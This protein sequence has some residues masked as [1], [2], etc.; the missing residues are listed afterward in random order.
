MLFRYGQQS[1]KRD[2][3]VPPSRAAERLLSAG[4]WP[5]QPVVFR[6]QSCST[7][8]GEGIRVVGDADALGRWGKLHWGV[9]LDTSASAYPAWSSTAPALLPLGAGFSWKLVA[10]QNSSVR[11]EGGGDRKSFA[12]P[13]VC[14]TSGSS[15][16]ELSGS[17][18]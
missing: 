18:R 5:T 6:C 12:V 10:R 15:A 7:A 3:E 13:P 8:W 11:W 9:G 2:G 17:W 16:M 1:V 4:G 14:R